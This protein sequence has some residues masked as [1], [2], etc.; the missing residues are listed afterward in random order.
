MELNQKLTKSM[1]ES[2]RYSAIHMWEKYLCKN[3]EVKE[4][5]GHLLEGGV[6]SCLS[7]QLSSSF[8]RKD[9]IVQSLL[10]LEKGH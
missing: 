6:F 1:S 3:L 8:H 9:V 2:T 10:I 5:G 4:E 7:K